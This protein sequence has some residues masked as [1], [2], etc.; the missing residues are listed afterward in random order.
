MRHFIMSFLY[1]HV[2]YFDYIYPI[3]F[4]CTIPLPLHFPTPDSLQFTSVKPP[5]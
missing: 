5:V 3:I 2:M 4:S 1:T